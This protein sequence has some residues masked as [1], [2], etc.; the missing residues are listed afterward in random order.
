[1]ST[2]V[3]RKTVYSEC[4]VLESMWRRSPAGNKGI[5]PL[6]PSPSP[7]DRSVRCSVCGVWKRTLAC[8][9]LLIFSVV[10]TIVI[11]I[12]FVFIAVI[13]YNACK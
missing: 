10:V 1:M 12:V 5:H 3:N 9:V 13:V 8:H 4:G 2:A 6:P 7:L 11:I